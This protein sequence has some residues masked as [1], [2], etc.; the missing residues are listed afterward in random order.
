MWLLEPDS[1]AN[2]KDVY[3]AK[4]EYMYMQSA[5]KVYMKI[6]KV[7]AMGQA[8]MPRYGHAACLFMKRYM[9]VYGGR[10]DYIM[11]ETSKFM[12]NDLHLYDISKYLVCLIISF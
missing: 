1:N 2:K 8:P 11:S 5:N 6:K 3:N 9:A 12:F 10:N 7:E 4:G